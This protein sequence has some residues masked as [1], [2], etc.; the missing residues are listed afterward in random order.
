MD[1]RERSQGA[2]LS[3]GFEEASDGESGAGK[4][5]CKEEYT[6]W[7]TSLT[8][9]TVHN[10]DPCLPQTVA[11]LVNQLPGEVSAFQGRKLSQLYL[12]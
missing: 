3:L 4:G 11:K 10:Q 1:V 12:L 5:T 9:H 2:V 7:S 8:Q 6:M